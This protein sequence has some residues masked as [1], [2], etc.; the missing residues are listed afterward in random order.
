[1][2]IPTEKLPVIATILA[3]YLAQP[4]TPTGDFRA[5]ARERCAVP[6]FENWATI[7][8]LK[9]DGT[10]FDYETVDWPG[11]RTPE[12]TDLWQR[13]VLAYGT[14]LHPRFAE[15]LPERPAEANNCSVC[16]GR[17]WFTPR[18]THAS[19]MVCA[20]CGGVGWELPA[21]TTELQPG[22]AA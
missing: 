7:T 16:E 17:G 15:L 2:S 12:H 18:N 14:R 10:F 21:Q 4:F 22:P 9:T 5:V 13:T 3:D 8:F 19:E 20:A 11:A 1:M 6:V